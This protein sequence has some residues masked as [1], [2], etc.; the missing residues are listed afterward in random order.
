[1]DKTEQEIRNGRF[2]QNQKKI[3]RI[4]L[5]IV[6]TIL[7]TIT[8]LLILKYGINYGKMYID[9][10]INRI[11]LK[12]TENYISLTNQN[13]KLIDEII[14]LNEELK[15]LRAQVLTLN[16]DINAYSLDIV[17]LKSSIEFVDTSVKDSILVQTE[18][19]NSI[20][21]LDNRLVALKNSLKILLEAP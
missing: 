11:E 20:M 5:G 3:I 16:E 14:L 7:L 1:M 6:V 10:G 19:E 18:L 4:V 13:Q 15:T 8:W 9:D 12:N 17:E 2:N 21:Q